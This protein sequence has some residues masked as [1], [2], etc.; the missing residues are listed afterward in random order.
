MLP[1]DQP[2]FLTATKFVNV[3]IKA[4]VAVHRATAPF[5]VAGKTYPAGSY[6]VKTAQPF[7][8][9]V[10]DMFE[11]QDHPNDFPYPGGPPRAPYDVTGYNLSYSMGIGFDRIL[12]PFEGPF[13]KLADTVS[14][15]A[16]RVAPATTGGG[17]L[18]GPETNDAFVAVNRLL[19]ANQEVYRLRSGALFVPATA[20]ALPILQRV[21]AE[22]GL[23]VEASASPAPGDAT[24]LRSMRVGLWDVYGG[25][26]PSG[27]TRW[28]LEQFEFPFE[29]VYQKGLDAGNLAGRF[30]VLIFVDGAFPA[31]E[32][33]E[34]HSRRRTECHP[35]TAII[36]VP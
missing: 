24:R 11:P 36:S 7:R 18:L 4:G 32:S 13:E 19:K 20:A 33:A 29:V 27:W 35:S 16:G 9:H 3:L 23:R 14:P 15:P 25:S 22:K 30:D 12:E 21:A 34:A 26:M 31:R 6:V 2:D 28:L 5:T 17:Y 10:M 1:S 8:A